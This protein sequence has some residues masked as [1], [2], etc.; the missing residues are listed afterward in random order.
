MDR[1]QTL[2]PIETNMRAVGRQER[3][4]FTR[5]Q[6]EIFISPSREDHLS[7]AVP[8]PVG[9]I[10]WVAAVADMQAVFAQHGKRPRL[11]Y[12][13]ELHPELAPALE[14]AGLVC[15]SRAPVMTLNLAELA[16]PPP[17][18]PQMSYQRLTAVDEPSLKAYLMNQ[19]VAYG[20]T[21][22]EDALGWLS[23]L[24]H[25]LANGRVQG[26]VLLQAG[27]MVSGAVIQIGDGIGE[28]AGVWS[29]PQW[30]NRGLAYAL[31][32]QLL[33]DYKAAGYSFCWLSAAEGAQRLY[34]K[35]GF[36]YVGVQLN[37]GL[38]PTFEGV[39]G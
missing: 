27:E 25:G 3:A 19:S 6:F 35:L 33:S 15:E 34:E 4:V 21:G 13:A 7:F 30:R 38:R 31:C 5:P 11:E 9:P 23:H 18:P 22:G 24:Q 20:G 28:L 17:Q 14:Q 10:D 32:W 29:A 8:L 26:A 12:I 37:Y 1:I 36:V 39:A 2:N 16:P